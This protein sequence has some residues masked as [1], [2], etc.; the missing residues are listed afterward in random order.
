MTRTTA[1]RALL[2]VTLIATVLLTLI[3]MMTGGDGD[4]VGVGGRKRD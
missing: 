4:L 3:V 2:T 1:L